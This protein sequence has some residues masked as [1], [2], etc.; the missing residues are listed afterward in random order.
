MPELLTTPGSKSTRRRAAE[1]ARRL[2]NADRRAAG[3]LGNVIRTL[4]P[5]VLL[6]GSNQTTASHLRTFRADLPQPLHDLR[7]D[8]DL[9][10]PADTHG[11]VILRDVGALTGDQQHAVLAWLEGRD[12]RGTIVS[13]SKQS[14][15][16]KVTGGEFLPT[17]YY[18]LNV[19]MFD[20]GGE[21]DPL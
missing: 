3:T 10:L 14:I 19:V 21:R 12:G 1:P 20:L 6:I 4:H 18:R 5:N 16:P 7:V 13:T 9:Q 17:L 11:T 8:A 2:G 15:Y